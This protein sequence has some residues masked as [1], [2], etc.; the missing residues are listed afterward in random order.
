MGRT[1][2]T[3]RTVC[4]AHPL[5]TVRAARTVRLAAGFVLGV[6][7]VWAASA[8]DI[9]KLRHA[10]HQV[11]ADAPQ[12]RFASWAELLAKARTLPA[13]DKLARVNDFF[14]QRLRFVDDAELWGHSD[15]WATPMQTLARGA[16]DCEDFAIAKYF[17]LLSL[18]IPV[19]RLRLTYVRAR[20]GG[21]L[22]AH[23]VLAYYPEPEADPLVLDNLV[24]AIL[25]ASR[26]PDLLPVF[27]F[28]SERVYQ[29][30]AG[31]K[32]SG[33]VG[34]LSRWQDALARSRNEG[35]D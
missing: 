25:P 28:N 27:N 32:A 3:A 10:Y 1:A 11:V 29:T 12:D 13:G 18:G 20:L 2:H 35:F 4:T 31:P 6:A 26:R 8:F 22:Q 19:E 24:R 17:T 15:Y 23:M 5:R 34:Q 14:N 30:G 33:H 9:D 16:G 21:A 7:C